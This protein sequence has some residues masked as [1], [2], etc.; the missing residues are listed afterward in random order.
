MT[1]SSAAGGRHCS[2]SVPMRAGG[3]WNGFGNG[4]D[5][6]AN[7]APPGDDNPQPYSLDILIAQQAFD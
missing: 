5:V 7:G 6:G 2:G 4:R 1:S 3:R